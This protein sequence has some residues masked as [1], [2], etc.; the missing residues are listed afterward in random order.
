MKQGFYWHVHH[1]ELLEWCWDEEERRVHIVSNKPFDEQKLRLRLFK[2]VLGVL[3]SDVIEARAAKA[4]AAYGKAGAAYGKAGAA[5]DKARAAYDKAVQDNMAAIET[6]H[7]QEC[8][9]CPWDGHTI[10]PGAK[11]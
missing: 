10:F 11:S 9:D 1:G 3:P 6:L 5:W 7:A 8:L 4:R 2:P